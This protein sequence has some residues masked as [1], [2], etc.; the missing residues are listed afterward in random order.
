MS[1]QKS[2]VTFVS[3]DNTTAELHTNHVSDV[4]QKI[5]IFFYK[6]SVSWETGSGPLHKLYITYN[7]YSFFLR[8]SITLKF[9]TIK[10]L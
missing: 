10:E 8:V 9:E 1:L 3:L 2:L 4:D 6:N 7:I 5:S